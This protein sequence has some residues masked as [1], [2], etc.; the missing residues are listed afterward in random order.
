[1]IY[2]Q[3]QYK[4]IVSYLHKFSQLLIENNVKHWLDYGTLLHGYRD[5]ALNNP[6]V[7][8]DGVSSDDIHLNEDDID[9]GCME[10]DYDR[11]IEICKNNNLTYLVI[12]PN[13]LLRL[14]ENDLVAI[15]KNQWPKPNSSEGDIWID[16]YFWHD[17]PTVDL[18]PTKG[19]KKTKPAL[20]YEDTLEAGDRIRNVIQ[21]L[22]NSS[23]FNWAT[24]NRNYYDY[25]WI[26][27]KYFVQELDTIELYGYRFPVPR[28]IERFLESRYGPQW[29]TPMTRE[30]YVRRFYSEEPQKYFHML[31]EDKIT[32]LI[33]GVW[34][35]FH[36]GHVELFKRARDVYDKVIV[37]VGSD[38]LVES[39]KRKPIIPYD[40]RVKLLES[41]KYVD[42][43]YH[44]AP[45]LNITE[46]VLDNCGADYALHSVKNPNNWKVELRESARYDQSLIDSG[47]AHFLS[48]TGYHSTD[49]ID[50]ILKDNK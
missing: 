48:Y 38:N 1:M 18:L 26:T 22:P 50:K 24:D 8:A 43:I 39:Y 21:N 32:V 4:Q 34:D 29:K 11:V 42:E 10:T 30:Y 28:Y 20:R 47:R 41:C 5:G 6:S 23:L 25:Y 13:Q 40:D 16:L 27:K 2:T 14:G 46:K 35:L 9:I 3:P 37:G 33:E 19:D 31:S 17:S 7:W 45:V 12:A 44:N 15:C 36:C 49:I